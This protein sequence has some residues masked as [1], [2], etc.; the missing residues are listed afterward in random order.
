[1]YGY[2]R[3]YGKIFGGSIGQTLADAYKARVEAD[4]GTYENNSCLVSF[5]NSLNPYSGNLLLGL[6]PN[7]AAAYS[8]RLLNP[9]YTGDAIRVRRSSDNTEQDIGFVSGILDT[10]SL[11]TFCGAGDGFVTTWYDQSGNAYDATQTTAASQPKIVSSGSVILENGKPSLQFDESDDWLATS[12]AYPTQEYQNTYYVASSTGTNNRIFDTRGTGAAGTV[13]GWQ[14]KFSNG[15]DVTAID[16]GAVI[17]LATNNI[18]R[19]GQKLV[20]VLMYGGSGSVIDEYTNSGSLVSASGISIDF[21]SGNALYI[22]ANVNGQTTQL[23]GGKLQEGIFYNI[24][25]SSN[26]T[27]IETNINTYYSIY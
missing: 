26:R 27:G 8:L 20:S 2:G 24:N 21:N 25:T 1:M 10:A 11:L 15:T 14:H 22:A 18:L 19:I 7:A 4:G 3:Q 16:S 17:N 13:K 23:F 12:V 9:D 5:I 6:Y